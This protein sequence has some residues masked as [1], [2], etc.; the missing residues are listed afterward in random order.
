MSAK[1][2]SSTE[3][4]CQANYMQLLT[5]YQ[6][7]SMK[8]NTLYFFAAVMF[9]ALSCKQANQQILQAGAYQIKSMVVNDGTKDSTY[10]SNQLKIYTGTH[11]I[12]VHMNTDSSVGFGLGTYHSEGNKVEEINW[13]NSSGSD[14]ANSFILNITPTDNGYTQHIPAI[15]SNGI[16]YTMTETYTKQGNDSTSELD[17]LWKQTVGLK[18][19]GTDTTKTHNFTHYTA[20]QNGHFIFVHRYASDSTGTMFKKGFGSGTFT[21]ANGQLEEINTLTNYP[22][23]AGKKITI[24][25]TF[26][27]KNEY[28]QIIKDVATQTTSIETYTRL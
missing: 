12:Y 1:T 25:I 7:K 5:N 8:K 13:Y 26:T 22:S 6:N 2:I 3:N 11:Y 10:Q 17:G 19:I 23:I 15:V 27:G 18:I 21:Y 24:S 20:F 4:F 28:T 16:K 9:L 14:T